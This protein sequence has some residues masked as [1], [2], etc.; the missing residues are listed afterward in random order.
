MYDKDMVSNLSFFPTTIHTRCLFAIERVCARSKVLRA[1][2][3]VVE[4]EFRSVAWCQMG[5]GGMSIKTQ[6][7]FH[8][9]MICGCA[10]V[11]LWVDF[12]RLMMPLPTTTT[13]TTV[14]SAQIFL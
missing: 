7:W 1:K 11:A 13:T 14:A 10:A 2:M 5:G 3:P 9:L 8:C 6:G 4:S 12:A